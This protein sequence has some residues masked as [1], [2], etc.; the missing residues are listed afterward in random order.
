MQNIDEYLAAAESS[1]PQCAACQDSG[2]QDDGDGDRAELWPCQCAAGD[3][4]RE[5]A[6]QEYAAEVARRQMLHAAMWS[7]VLGGVAL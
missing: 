2:W 7:V 3:C 1:G 6:R 5:Q 4:R